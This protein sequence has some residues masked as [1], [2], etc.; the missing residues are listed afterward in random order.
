VIACAW[1]V[2][3]IRQANDINA[4]TSILSQSGPLRPAQAKHVSD[5]LDSAATLNPD[6]QV[7]VLR[8]DLATT[9]GRLAQARVILLRVIHDEPRNVNAWLA[10]TQATRNNGKAFLDAVNHVHQIVAHLKLR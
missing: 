4:A 2:F 6:R 1:F 5:L 9:E 8:G 7:D 10:Y 3:G